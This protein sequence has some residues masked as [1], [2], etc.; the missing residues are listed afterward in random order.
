MANKSFK[1]NFYGTWMPKIYGLGAAVVIVGAM[2]K[3]NGYPF[4]TEM[5]LLGLSTEALIFVFSAFEPRAK[6]LAEVFEK[7]LP[8]V[9]QQKNGQGDK[10]DLKKMLNDAKITGEDFKNLGVGMNNLSNSAKGLSDLS[11]AAVA[12]SAYA[13]N[14]KKASETL[15]K[16]N[17]SYANT[18][19]ALQSMVEFTK[20]AG[21]VQGKLKTAAGQY[22]EQLK[23]ASVQLTALNSVY[24]EELNDSQT[25][26]KAIKS[27]YANIDTA[28]ASV[29]AATKQ[30]EEFKAVMAKLNQNVNS[31]NKVYGAMLSAMKTN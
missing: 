3:L 24:K 29:G 7:N 19:V 30:T 26:V 31:L 11:N 18:A 1:E 12:S 13:D 17:Q 5:L 4:A 9:E 16:M 14:A 28:L 27:F 21:D 10:V 22:Q 25:H 20:G 8:K 2:F 6:D 15:G 23:N